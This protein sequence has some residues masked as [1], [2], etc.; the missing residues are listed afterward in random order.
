MKNFTLHCDGLTI[1]PL[2][3][4]HDQVVFDIGFTREGTTILT[5]THETDCGDILAIS[6]I[7]MEIPI[8]ISEI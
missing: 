3:R 2:I 1:K 5:Y 8:T 6:N 7:K 4:D